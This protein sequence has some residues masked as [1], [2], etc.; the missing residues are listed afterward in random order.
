MDRGV[1]SCPGY[2]E[3]RQLGSLRSQRK[4][5]HAVET[6]FDTILPEPGWAI[7]L[8]WAGRYFRGCSDCYPVGC[9]GGFVCYPIIRPKKERK[10]LTSL[11][12]DPLSTVAPF[13]I[14]NW[15]IDGSSLY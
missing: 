6:D 10:I 5:H 1:I 4:A 12:L 13:V 8:P 7:L 14:G 2:P 3:L 9:A 11:F 15:K